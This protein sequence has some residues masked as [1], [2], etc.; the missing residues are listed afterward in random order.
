VSEILAQA[1]STPVSS[2]ICNPRRKG[3]APVE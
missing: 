3:M 2:A 1:G